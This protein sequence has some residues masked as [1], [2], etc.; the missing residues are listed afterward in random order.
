MATKRKPIRIF[1][2]DM[3]RRFYASN[4]YKIVKVEGD[5]EFVEIT[6]QKD[7]VTQ[8]IASLIDT[9]EIT[10]TVRPMIAKEIQ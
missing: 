2:S 5:K 7:D 10:F 6:G 9:H 8:Q 3:S 4:Q 1:Y